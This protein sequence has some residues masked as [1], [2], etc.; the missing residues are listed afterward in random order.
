MFRR[1]D[2]KQV[3]NLFF[4]V[5]TEVVGTERGP[6]EKGEPAWGRFKSVSLPLRNILKPVDHFDLKLSEA[7]K[8]LWD[9]PLYTGNI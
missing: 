9:N 6:K 5:M 1:V 4:K 3:Y 2:D 7:S 8:K